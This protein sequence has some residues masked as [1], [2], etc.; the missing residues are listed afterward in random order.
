MLKEQIA[1]T[2]LGLARIAAVAAATVSMAQAAQAAEAPYKLGYLVDASGPQS[3]TLK[4]TFDAFQLYIAQLNR[5]GGVNGR[6]VQIVTRDIQSDTQRS[7]NAVEQLRSESVSAV[8]GLGATNTHAPVYAAAQ[9][10]GLPVLASNPINIPI[11]LPPVKPYAF[12]LGQELSLAGI[13]GGHFAHRLRPQGKTIACVA[14]EVPGSIL[15]CNKILEQAKA[16]GFQRGELY[17]VPIS[18]RDFR[19]VVDRIVSLNP[20]VVADCIGR[21]H[22]AALLPV[23][24]ASAYS[25]IFL[26]MDTGIGD[27]TLIDAVPANS[28]LQVYSFTRF[29]THGDGAGPQASALRTALAAAHMPDDDASY[30]GGWALGLV[31]TDALRRCQGACGPDALR[32]ALENVDID[33]GGLTGAR[34]TFTPNDHYGPSA[35]RLYRY[36]AAGKSLSAVGGWQRI[37]SDGKLTP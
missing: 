22:L 23:L 36:D 31:V 13:I 35:W 11:V 16:E 18:Q 33:S 15:S 10:L 30:A 37:A 1:A 7:L 8:L 9:K 34:L 26:S 19:A 2:L 27:K 4:P 12:G 17:T 3:T 20:D 25:G 14:F 29:V 24:A 32:A 28:K 6:Q 5:A 21:E